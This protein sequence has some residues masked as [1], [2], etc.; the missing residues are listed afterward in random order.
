MH[1]LRLLPGGL[2]GRCHRGGTEFRVFHRDP[3]GALLRQGTA[4]GE[5]RPLGARDRQEP[6]ARCAVPVREFPRMGATLDL[7]P[8]HRGEVASHSEPGEGTAE[9]LA[10]CIPLTPA[11]SPTGRRGI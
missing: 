10:P 6:G 1:L 2:P 7:T 9:S 3:R 4:A 11:L 5:W 8:P